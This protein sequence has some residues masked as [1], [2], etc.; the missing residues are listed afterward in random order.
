[1][2]SGDDRVA[3]STVARPRL[4][5][6]P[7]V[8]GVCEPFA[9]GRRRQRSRVERALAAAGSGTG[10]VDRDRASEANTAT[11][12]ELCLLNGVAASL[13]SG[14][15]GWVIGFGSGIIRLKVEGS[16]FRT[17]I[18]KANSS[19]KTFGLMG[20]MYT[21]MACAARKIRGKDDAV[22]LAIA[23]CASGIALGWEGGPV[24]ALQSCAGMGAFSWF[25]DGKRL[26]EKA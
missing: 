20:G 16:R 4:P 18:Q 17:S 12:Q 24:S 25:F 14:F 21:F 6:L 22:N 15:L 23:G 1:M 19:S 2:A 8:G 26:N 9:R 13:G 7:C 3:S 11:G 5:R 10:A